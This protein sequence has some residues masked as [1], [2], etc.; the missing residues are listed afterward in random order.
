MRSAWGSRLDDIVPVVPSITLPFVDPTRL[1]PTA[2]CHFA[3]EHFP[4]PDEL[5]QRKIIPKVTYDKIKDQV[6]RAAGNRTVALLLVHGVGAQD[7]G[8]MLNTFVQSFKHLGRYSDQSDPPNFTAHN[9]VIKLYEVYWADILKGDTVKGSFNDDLIISASWF[10][11]LNLRSGKYHEREYSSALVWFRIPQL[12]LLGLAFYALHKGLIGLGDLLLDLMYRLRR[13][14]EDC[15]K[16]FRALRVSKSSNREPKTQDAEELIDYKLDEYLGDVFTYANSSVGALTEHSLA[17]SSRNIVMRF[18]EQLDQAIRDGCDE[19]HL[20]AHSLGTLV[21]YHGLTA[22]FSPPADLNDAPPADQGLP[23]LARIYTIGSPLEKILFLWPKLIRRDLPGPLGVF[24]GKV[25]PL[26]HTRPPGFEWHNFHDGLDPVAGELKRLPKWTNVT[27]HRSFGRGGIY[28]AHFNYYNNPEVLSIVTQG[29]LGKFDNAG[30]RESFIER[31]RIF[32]LALGETVVA[33]LPVS[34]AVLYAVLVTYLLGF[35]FGLFWGSV[36]RTLGWID[37]SDKFP[38]RT[39]YGFLLLMI[40]LATIVGHQ[41][42]T[43]AHKKYWSS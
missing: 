40:V 36:A 17:S 15:V 26:E 7:R 42:S 37:L 2:P 23:T 29:L 10:P 43:R 6:K 39:G 38:Q 41:L 25:V 22:Y 4:A 9:R 27:N 1:F 24:N 16:P 19:I 18:N 32:G 13:V 33:L 11:Y 12:V 31:L 5:A 3:I 34:L 21:M 20:L 28:R 14:S 35:A 30:R 8:E